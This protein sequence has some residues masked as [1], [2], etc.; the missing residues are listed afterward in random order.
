MSG[1]LE[2]AAIVPDD[3]QPDA[4]TG[5]RMRLHRRNTTTAHSGIDGGMA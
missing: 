5:T 2:I 4:C 3:A 1:R